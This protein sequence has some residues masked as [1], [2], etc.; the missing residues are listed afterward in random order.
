MLQGEIRYATLV[1]PSRGG[2]DADQMRLGGWEDTARASVTSGPPWRIQRVD[3]HLSPAARCVDEST[4][5][6]VDADM[7]NMATALNEEHQVAGLPTIRRNRSARRCELLAGCA[8]QRL[9][10]RLQKNEAGEPRAVE[11]LRWRCTAVAVAC[12]DESQGPHQ[13]IFRLG[14]ERRGAA[15]PASRQGQCPRGLAGCGVRQALAANHQPQQQ[16]RTAE[17]ATGW[18]PSP[19]RW[20]IRAPRPDPHGPGVCPS[21]FRGSMCHQPRNRLA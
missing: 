12:S 4:I 8:R 3:P 9:T 11:A 13:H 20:I 10:C 17:Q 19:H 14:V 18:R 6:E 1:H 5:A 2:S 21:Q 7:I 16:P 15:L